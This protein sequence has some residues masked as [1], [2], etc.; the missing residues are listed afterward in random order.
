MIFSNARVKDA[1]SSAEWAKK[2]KQNLQGAGTGENAT[3]HRDR[4]KPDMA[5]GGH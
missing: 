4:N 1:E 5:P 3:T 2:Q